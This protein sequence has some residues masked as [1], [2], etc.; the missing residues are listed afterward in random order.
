ML[1]LIFAESSLELVPRELQAHR[2]VVSHA[3]RLG[4]RPGEILLDVSWHYAAMRGI[5]DEMK[6]GRPDLIHMCLQNACSTPLYL[7]GGLAI[8]IHTISGRVITIGSGIRLPKSYHRFAGLMERLFLDGSVEHEGRRMLD[9]DTMGLAEVIEEIRPG[10][11]LG[12]STLGDRIQLPR[13]ASELAGGSC[14]VIGGFQRGHFAP[15]VSSVMDATYRIG[16]DP[17]EAHVVTSRVLYEYEKTV[18]M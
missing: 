12:L 9:L 16:D 3:R 7:R 8:Y 11:I 17:L 15:H 10:A 18:F 4:K 13:L 1:S 2:S 14:V 6:R 5:K